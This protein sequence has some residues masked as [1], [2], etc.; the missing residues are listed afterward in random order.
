MEKLIEKA[1]ILLESLPYIRKF[2]GKT[3]VI[4]YGG[5]AMV[6]DELK[7]SF[8]EDVVLLK[9]VGINPIVVHGGG[10]Q[11]G[12]VLKKL[13]IKSSFA[14]GM[15]ITDSETMKVVQMVLVGMV[16]KEV[17]SLINSH[18]GTAVGL[19]GKDGKLLE[20]ER[21]NSS[22]YLRSVGVIENVDL[23]YVGSIKKVNANIIERLLESNFIPVVAPVAFGEGNETYNVNADTVAGEIAASVRAEKLIMLTD[24]RGI[25]NKQGN[26]ISTLK[27]IEISDLIRN[28]TISG[29][30]IP[31]VKACEIALMSGVK[32]AHI[33]DG[34]VKHSILLEIFTQKG[35]GTQIT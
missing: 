20:A 32:K 33:I 24:I 21:I 26:L 3:V 14:G 5:N 29:G 19:S 18:G 35:I 10:P 16:N 12:E 13:N 6:K 31:K 17:V 27:R 8:A 15:R 4:K 28:K 30:M 11:I 22:D 9:Y 23:G 1:S 25:K 34:R 7:S 2:Y